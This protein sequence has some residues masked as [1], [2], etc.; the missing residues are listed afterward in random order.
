[1]AMICFFYY[2]IF[3]ARKS[4]PVELCSHYY[5]TN[6]IFGQTQSP[7]CESTKLK[8]LFLGRAIDH[9]QH[10]LIT[11]TLS[12]EKES[13]YEVLYVATLEANAPLAKM[14]SDQ[15]IGPIVSADS[16]AECTL[17]HIAVDFHYERLVMRVQPRQKLFAPSNHLCGQNLFLS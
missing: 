5:T 8:W 7:S 9:F 4:W 2:F 15:A 11:L 3:P 6:L 16:I 14:F 13:R 12:M 10:H 1:M 17:R